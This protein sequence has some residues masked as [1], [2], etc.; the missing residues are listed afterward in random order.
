[1]NEINEQFLFPL[2]GHTIT[3]Q[4]IDPTSNSIHFTLFATDG[5]KEIRTQVDIENIRMF[6]YG[7]DECYNGGSSFPESAYDGAW[8]EVT[9][10]EAAKPGLANVKV[11]FNYSKKV[12]SPYFSADQ[13]IVIDFPNA[14]LTVSAEKVIINGTCFVWSSKHGH[15]ERQG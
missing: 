11:H 9:E 4:K 13:N 14:V 3:E 5:G 8:S 12:P 7:T 1:M 2:W 15:F 10:I 6:C